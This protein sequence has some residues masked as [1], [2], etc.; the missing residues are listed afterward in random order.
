[1]FETENIWEELRRHLVENFPT[2]SEKGI[3]SRLEK[4]MNS[5]GNMRTQDKDV[6]LYIPEF[7]G[8][9]LRVGISIKGTDNPYYYETDAGK[10]VCQM[11]SYEYVSN[12]EDIWDALRMQLKENFPTDP[13]RTIELRL[14]GLMKAKEKAKADDKSLVLYIPNINGEV[15]RVGFGIEGTDTVYYVETDAGR[16]LTKSLLCA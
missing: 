6:Q 16:D 9:V 3:D 1:M 2:D 10:R 15:L 12:T 11:L 13:D 14:Q 5:K 7:R 8:K 4:L